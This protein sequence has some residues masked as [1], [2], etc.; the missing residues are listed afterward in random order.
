MFNLTLQY[1]HQQFLKLTLIFT[2][3]EDLIQ[4]AKSIRFLIARKQD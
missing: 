3:A 1:P 2:I 4:F